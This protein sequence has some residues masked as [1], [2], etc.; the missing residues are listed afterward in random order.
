MPVFG[1]EVEQMKIECPNCGKLQNIPNVYINK[2]TVKC[3]KCKSEIPVTPSKSSFPKKSVLTGFAVFFGLL[4]LIIIL[5]IAIPSNE[6]EHSATKQKKYNREV[7]KPIPQGP[8]E[9]ALSPKPTYSHSPTSRQEYEERQKIQASRNY[10]KKPKPKPKPKQR[11]YPVDEVFAVGYMGYSVLSAEWK[12]KLADGFG[13]Y[14]YP[15]AAFLL[16]KIFAM[17]QDKKAR[18]IPPFH[19]IDETGSEY[20][21]SSKGPSNTLDFLVSLNPGVSRIGLI[22]FDAPKD[23]NYLLK[24]SGGYWSLEDVFVKI[25]RN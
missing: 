8:K 17:N 1:T 10:E 18:M 12:D 15:D 13:G 11:I 4:V 9:P 3:L 16:L 22:I 20:N 6:P 7:E 14:D 2:K 24:L 25:P 21:T 19:L 23:H 5:A